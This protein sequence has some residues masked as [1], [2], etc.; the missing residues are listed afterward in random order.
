[1]SILGGG[2][3]GSVISGNA[4][5]RLMALGAVCVGMTR[6]LLGTDII[7]RGDG[8]VDR[9]LRRAFPQHRRVIERIRRF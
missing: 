2:H 5:E 3:S 1:M 6:P 4:H 9:E 8:R 7:L